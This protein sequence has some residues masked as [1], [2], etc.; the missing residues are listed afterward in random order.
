MAK[1]AK[2]HQIT[3][4]ERIKYGKELNI[5]EYLVLIWCIEKGGND[6]TLLV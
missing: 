2:Q 5:Q 4:I 6:S 3:N 1:K